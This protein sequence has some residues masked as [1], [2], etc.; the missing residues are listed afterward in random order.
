MGLY[1]KIVIYIS[2]CI[3]TFL[4]VKWSL[5]TLESPSSFNSVLDESGEGI[6]LMMGAVDILL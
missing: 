6:H 3:R 5:V 1:F 2:V 4:C